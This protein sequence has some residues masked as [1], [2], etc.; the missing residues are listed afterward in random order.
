MAERLYSFLEQQI[1]MDWIA[2]GRK[3]GIKVHWGE[4]GNE[5]FLPSD[6]ATSVVRYLKKRA[7]LPFVFDTTTLYKAARNSVVG[8]LTVA[9][10]HNYGYSATGAPLL[11]GD[12]PTGIDIIEIPTQEKALH[13]RTVKVAALIERVGGVITLS[14]FKGHLAA[15]FGAA[16]KNISMGIASRATKQRMHSDVVPDLTEDN[17]VMCGTCARVCPVDAIELKDKPVFDLE[18]CI[19]CAECI[20]MCPT[21]AL[22]I[23]WDSKGAK[24]CEKLVET[25]SAICNYL[26][27]R[28]LHIVVLANITPECDCFGIKLKIIAPNIGILI[29]EDPVAVDAAACALFNASSPMPNSG[30]SKNCKDKIS[31]LHPSVD[32]RRQFEYAHELGMGNKDYDLV[33]V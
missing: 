13:F 5:T 14:H 1:D 10:E 31:A 8:A 25:A 20:S 23:R 33:R 29:S 9:E 26:K 16:I 19:G 22:D 32:W 12:G 4:Q 24:F 15:G 7:C 6:Y 30:L 28:M 17:C 21:D 18:N 11:I 2:K 27:P 3:I